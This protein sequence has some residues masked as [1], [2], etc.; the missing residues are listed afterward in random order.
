[1]IIMYVQYTNMYPWK[2]NQRYVYL[3]LTSTNQTSENGTS[4]KKASDW[5]ESRKDL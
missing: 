1:V 5:I 3:D 4:K 2:K